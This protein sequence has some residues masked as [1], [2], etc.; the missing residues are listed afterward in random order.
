MNNLLNELILTLDDLVDRCQ[1]LLDILKSEKQAILR[2]SVDDLNAI[3]YKKGRS[4]S[5]DPGDRCQAV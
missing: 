1:A 2:A 3:R 5:G 4:D